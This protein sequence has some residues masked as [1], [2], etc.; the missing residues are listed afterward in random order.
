MY[1][2]FVT[3]LALVSINAWAQSGPN[4]YEVYIK[5]VSAVGN[6]CLDGTARTV[7]SPDSKTMSVLFDEYISEIDT[8]LRILDH[9]NCQLT[10]EMNIP[11]GWSYSLASA[12]YRGFAELDSNTMGVQEIVYLFADL[13]V[14]VFEG[15]LPN[16]S[17]VARKRS[18]TF[19]SRIIRGPFSGDYS[20]TN[21][22]TVGEMPWS[23][24][25]SRLNRDL[26]I[27]TTL[28]TRSLTRA[29]TKVAGV[30]LMALDSVDATVA[31]EF[32]LAWR[33]CP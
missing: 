8:S 23:S 27:Q 7:L 10:I 15:G 24:C 31:Q 11:T 28:M 3:V 21:L 1:I 20:F 6:G 12:D 22:V 9:K 29:P 5:N 14:P 19:S 32:E 2:F 26:K 18:A 4:P 13:G 30:A 16:R 25:D 17:A 33:Q